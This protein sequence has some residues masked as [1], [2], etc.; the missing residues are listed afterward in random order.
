M[1]NEECMSCQL[2]CRPVYTVQYGCD[3][4]WI[5]CVACFKM[6]TKCPNHPQ[7]MVAAK[8]GPRGE[9]KTVTVYNT[10]DYSKPCAC[11]D[12]VFEDRTNVKRAEYTCGDSI[13]L[14]R[15][16]H[17]HSTRCKNHSYAN[18]TPRSQE[19]WQN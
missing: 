5:L 18:E 8:W 4:E 7:S 13:F 10:E 2:K 15:Q 19:Q 11:C 3:C 9:D 14:C 6:V 16:C 17:R 1:A 12:L